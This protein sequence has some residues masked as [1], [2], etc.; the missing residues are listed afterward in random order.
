M[1]CKNSVTR[2]EPSDRQ[3]PREAD[4]VPSSPKLNDRREGSNKAAQAAIRS[5]LGC[6][7]RA[8]GE[9]DAS[10][11][12][13]RLLAVAFLN[14]LTDV[15]RQVQRLKRDATSALIQEECTEKNLPILTSAI[16]EIVEQA[17]DDSFARVLSAWFDHKLYA[18]EVVDGS[19]V[20]EMLAELHCYDE[21]PAKCTF[22]HILKAL[23]DY[24]R[25]ETLWELFRDFSGGNPTMS[26]EE[27][28]RFFGNQVGMSVKYAADKLRA[29]FGN[30]LTRFTFALFVSSLFGNNV[31]DPQRVSTVWQ[32]MTQPLPQYMVHTELVESETGFDAALTNGTR[33]FVL[34]I[35]RLPDG[36][37][38]SGSCPLLSLLDLIRTKGFARNTYPIVVCL[39]PSTELDVDTQTEVAETLIDIL[40]EEMLARGIM[41]SGST[42]NDPQFSP[43]A[44]QRKVLLVSKQAPLRPFVG[45]FV[46][47]TNRAGLGVRV[48]NVNNDTPAEKAGIVKDDWL[49]H[50]NGVAIQSRDHLKTI[51]SQLTLGEEFVMRKENLE[52]VHLLLGGAVPADTPDCSKRLSD[53]TFL[54]ITDEGSSNA[55]LAPWDVVP[56]EVSDIEPTAA[57]R[58][59]LEKHFSLISVDKEVGDSALGCCALSGTQLISISSQ[60]FHQAWALGLFADNAR[61]GY[62]YKDDVGR[63]RRSISLQFI[64]PTS[65]LAGWV[66][67]GVSAKVIGN[68]VIEKSSAANS[69]KV[70][71]TDELSVLVVTL[72]MVK[73]GVASTMLCCSPATIMR[74]GYRAFGAVRDF[75][76]GPLSE[77]HSLVFL[78]GVEVTP[79]SE[80]R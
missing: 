25:N 66:V 10:A 1:G 49:T 26:A 35:E 4:V 59:E 27:L 48:T 56:R 36:T 46:A 62:I 13:K 80:D 17:R 42:L 41:F 32:D 7:E 60:P 73:D 24:S 54:K 3:P 20:R 5:V 43:A 57:A 14:A 16:P 79:V 55:P 8:F 61:C 28:T 47:D 74:A 69:V 70:S 29:R 12:E 72:N 44:L 53:I 50:I 71:Y 37:F 9:M 19:V 68:G 76:P 30:A 64:C 23:L 51:L 45:F 58:K 2:P 21:V 52:E 39:D 15:I 33:A 38:V 11:E 6:A 22:Y 63:V 75:R 65:S 78:V 67:E 34:R 40:G 77:V 18:E 31:H